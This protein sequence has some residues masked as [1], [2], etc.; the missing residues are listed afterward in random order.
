MQPHTNN[1]S[2][3]VLPFGVNAFEPRNMKHWYEHP[4]FD[5]VYVDPVTWRCYYIEDSFVYTMEEAQ[6]LADSYNGGQPV[7]KSQLISMEGDLH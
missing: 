3:P 6:E 2:P 5:V 7:P 4:A 1:P